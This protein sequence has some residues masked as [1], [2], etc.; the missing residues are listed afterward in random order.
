MP[1]VILSGVLRSIA[2]GN[3]S[4]SVSGCTL[5]EVLQNLGA[6]HPDIGR[7]LFGETGQLRA[8]YIV[9][10]ENQIVRQDELAARRVDDTSH[11][12]IYPVMAGG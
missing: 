6:S 9:R 2:G 4:L 8:H 11:I 12:T 10:L 1:N 3:S 7:A 5:A